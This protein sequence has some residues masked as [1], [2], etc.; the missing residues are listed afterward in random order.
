M[1]E[2]ISDYKAAASNQ[3]KTILLPSAAFNGQQIDEKELMESLTDLP[4]TTT[5]KLVNKRKSG[6]KMVETPVM[7]TTKIVQISRTNGQ[8]EKRKY[9]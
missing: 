5:R 7:G 1:G 8:H 2:P 9:L 4:T 6:I 3:Q